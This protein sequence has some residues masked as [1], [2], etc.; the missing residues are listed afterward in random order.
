MARVLGSQSSY[1]GAQS[2]WAP[3]PGFCDFS[4]MFLPLCWL[5]AASQPCPRVHFP[6]PCWAQA[7]LLP[8]PSPLLFLGA[9]SQPRCPRRVLTAWGGPRLRILVKWA[10][11]QEF[12]QNRHGQAP[13]DLS[14]LRVTSVS[15]GPPQRWLEP[16][17]VVRHNVPE[18]GSEEERT[19]KSI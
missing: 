13:G 18:N 17:L 4:I 19:S 5:L 2:L 15:V 12:R 9:Q 11:F 1:L 3:A 6:N 10:P 16:G 8:S 14:D 7:D